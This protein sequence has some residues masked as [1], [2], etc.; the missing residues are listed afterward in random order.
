MEK[1]KMKTS[2]FQ[3]ELLKS[4]ID[5]NIAHKSLINNSV[6]CPSDVKERLIHRVT[7]TN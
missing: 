3:L 1:S 5:L 2:K 7:D 6:L 4:C